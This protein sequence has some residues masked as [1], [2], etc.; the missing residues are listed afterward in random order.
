MNQPHIGVVTPVY[1]EQECLP[2]FR[3]RLREVLD[4]L[5]CRY[6]VY[7]IDDGSTDA[8]PEIVRRFAREDR[9]WHGVFL[10]R[11]FGHQAAITAGL[12]AARG[13]VIVVMDGDLQDEPEAI[14]KMLAQWRQKWEK[15]SA[16]PA[17]EK[18]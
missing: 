5:D 15:H 16:P 1:N 14:P 3:D 17:A 9:R 2:Q 11:N 13:D 6:D 8:T 12:E 18:K 7:L 10:A 4:G